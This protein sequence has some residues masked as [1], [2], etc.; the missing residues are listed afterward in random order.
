MVWGQHLEGSK[1]SEHVEENVLMS[2]IRRW[3]YESPGKIMIQEV[4]WILE[5][6]N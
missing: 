3:A 4:Q 5:L 2:F 6:I 1:E